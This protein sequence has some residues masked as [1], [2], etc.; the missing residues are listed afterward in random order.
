MNRIVSPG[1]N[2]MFVIDENKELWAWGNNSYNKLG[3]SKQEQQEY[4]TVQ[5]IK[6]NVNGNKVKKVFS[7]INNTFVLTEN[8]ELYAAGNNI[9]GQLGIGYIS[10]NEDKFVK[11]NFENPNTILTISN[12]SSYQKGI[13]I[14]TKNENHTSIY[15]AGLTDNS[16]YTNKIE[17]NVCTFNKIYDGNKGELIANE[18]VSLVSVEDRN[19]FVLD[20]KGLLYQI[21]PATLSLSNIVV[22]NTTGD[23][24]MT[25]SL[26]RGAIVSKIV[27][28]K[29]HLYFYDYD[30]TWGAHHLLDSGIKSTINGF[31]EFNE[32]ITKNLDLNQIKDIFILGDKETYILMNDGRIYAKGTNE[33]FG[34]GIAVGNTINEFR[35]IQDYTKDLPLIESF[36]VAKDKTAFSDFSYGLLKDKDNNYYSIGD[37]DLILREKKFQKSWKHIASNVKKFK[38]TTAR[39]SLAYIDNNN[40]IWVIGDSASMLGCNTQGIDYQIPNFVRLK[41]KLEGLEVYNNISGKVED[42][43]IVGSALYIKTNSNDNNSLYVSGFCKDQMRKTYIGVTNDSY[44]PTKIL[45]DIENYCIDFVTRTYCSNKRKFSKKVV[46]MG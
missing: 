25:R 5:A 34:E 9:N 28:E 35:C 17:N 32:N 41:D 1:F 29:R 30:L 44:I 19:V 38:A 39:N 2:N 33:Y 24:E 26:G 27:D 45:S 31:V 15:Y 14:L 13:C 7:L 20:N 36:C 43:A 10:S 37:Q 16:K 22:G 12:N 8:N 18:I 6:L 42:Y 46:D 21:N 3:L 4:T 11:V 23:I 40:D